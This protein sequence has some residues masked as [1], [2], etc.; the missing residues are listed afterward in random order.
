[1]TEVVD[2]WLMKSVN[3]PKS[4]WYMTWKADK[5]EVI[6]PRYFISVMNIIN[7]WSNPDFDMWCRQPAPPDVATFHQLRV[8]LMARNN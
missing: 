3:P 6:F 7:T 8:I 4:G 5:P 1:M 2:T